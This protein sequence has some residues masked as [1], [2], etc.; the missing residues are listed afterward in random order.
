VRYVRYRIHPLLAGVLGDL[1]GTA[2][3]QALSDRLEQLATLAAP[4]PPEGE[5]AT[6]LAP[7]LWL[8]D[9]AANGGLP[10]TSAGYLKPADVKS[11]A[12]M[13]PTMHDWIFPITREVDV[14]PVL[15]FREHL[16]GVGLLRKSRGALLATVAGR[17]A[18]EHPVALWQ[19][20]AGRIVPSRPGFDSVAWTLVLLHAATSDG[21]RL[22]LHV[23]AQTLAQLGWA[24]AGGAPILAGDVQ[25]TWNDVWVALGNVGPRPDASRRRD[26]MLSAA[27]VTLT[28]DVLLTPRSD[29]QIADE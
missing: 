12:P 7:H 25:W 11:F 19:H 21:D 17:R 23:V 18:A 5:L 2:L 27:A 10:L 24:H 15:Y 14:H 28:R 20:L 6:L 13:L 29:Q 16:R 1:H 8:L 26:R 4:T 22:N 3:G 9:R